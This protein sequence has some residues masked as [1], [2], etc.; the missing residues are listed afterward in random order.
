MVQDYTMGGTT[1]TQFSHEKMTA[2]GKYLWLKHPQSQEYQTIALQI[3]EDFKAKMANA[4]SLQGDFDT[5][6]NNYIANSM[7]AYE[8]VMNS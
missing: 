6:F 7:A 8:G 4:T 5:E 3:R 1:T 2:N